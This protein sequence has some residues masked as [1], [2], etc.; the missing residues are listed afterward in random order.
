[1]SVSTM[2]GTDVRPFTAEVAEEDITDLRRRL[3]ATRWPEKETVTDATQGVQLATAAI[4]DEARI[5]RIDKQSMLQL[6]Q[7]D[8][9]FY[10]LF[11]AYMEK[12]GPVSSKNFLSVHS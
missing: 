11:L 4:V 8:R 6:L 5:V 1:M 7:D 12:P 3:E 2:K 9:T 10:D